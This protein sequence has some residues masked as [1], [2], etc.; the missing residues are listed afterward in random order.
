[1]G[2][3]FPLLLTL[4][5]VIHSMTT[6]TAAQGEE[7]LKALHAKR[8]GKECHDKVPS[9]DAAKKAFVRANLEGSDKVRDEPRIY[10]NIVPCDDGHRSTTEEALASCYLAM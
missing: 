5:I 10:T 3:V 7:V 2:G 4:V 6:V 1:M 9:P 8:A